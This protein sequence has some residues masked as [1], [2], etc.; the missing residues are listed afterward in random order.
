MSTGRN[1]DLGL[2]LSQAL[3]PV[4]EQDEARV[5]A[6]T[7][8]PPEGGWSDLEKQKLR[9]GLRYHLSDAEA[10]SFTGTSEAEWRDQAE[11]I[12]DTRRDQERDPL[13]A[14]LERKLTPTPEQPAPPPVVLRS[15]GGVALNSDGLVDTLAKKLG[16]KP[17]QFQK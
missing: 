12:L 10:L 8:A 2:A 9:V 4:S 16:M 15:G 5:A 1:T 6:E 7:L 13:K 17:T 14:A 3:R 11:A